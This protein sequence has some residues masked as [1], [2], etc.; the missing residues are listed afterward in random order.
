[1]NCYNGEK[2]LEESVNSILNQ[3]FSNWELIFWD[4][5]STD[6]SLKIIK[7][8]KD[9]RI[10]VFKS[11][12][13]YPLGQARNLA[14]QKSQ[15]EFIAFLDCDDVWMPKKLSLQIPKF[16][17]EKVGLVITDTIFFNKNNQEKQLYKKIKPKEGNVFKELLKNYFI[18]LETVVIRKKSLDTL[19]HY[20]D[21]RFQMIEEYDLFLRIAHKWQLAY[22][23]Q[24]LAK[25]RVHNNSWTWR[26][27]ELFPIERIMMI[28]KF[29]SLIPQFEKS[30]A[31]ELIFLKNLIR[32]EE[33]INLWSKRKNFEARKKIKPLINLSLK[34]SILHLLMFFPFNF[35]TTIKKIKGDILP[36]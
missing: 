32:Y 20:F 19:D 17:S 31:D 35:F 21:D 6:N 2:F 34:W 28:E 14:L 10:K 16:K 4:N 13:N 22:V 26:R 3:T 23:D 5:A 1:M 12:I 18:S 11:K 29:K 7:L 15:G 33:A 8:F 25:W 30:Y 27:S 9:K 24:V 36:K